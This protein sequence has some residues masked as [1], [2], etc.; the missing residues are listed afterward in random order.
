MF[1]RRYTINV[2]ILKKRV[3]NKQNNIKIDDI[4][5]SSHRKMF[6]I[7]NLRLI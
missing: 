4:N 3:F 6:T 2:Q 1:N 7:G 5:T